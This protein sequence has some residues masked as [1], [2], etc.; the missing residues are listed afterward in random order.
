M[1][2]NP[3][4]QKIFQI[5]FILI[6][7][8]GVILILRQP[9][10]RPQTPRMEKV[11]KD[12]RKAKRRFDQRTAEA[13]AKESDVALVRGLLAENLGD[14]TFSFATVCEAVSGKK[15]IPLDQSPPQQRVIKAIEAALSKILPQLSKTD[16]PIRKLRRINEAS[17]FFEDALL[18][19]LNA[20][21]GLK[22]EIPSTRDGAHQRS[23]YPDLRITDQKTGTVF[24]L[25]PKL[26]EQGS[27]NSTFRSFYFEPKTETSKIHDDAVHLLVGIEHNGKTRAWTFSGWRIVDLSTMEVRLKAEF[28]ATNADLY[29]ETELSLPADKP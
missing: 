11:E 5:I 6:A 22:C 1:K 3:S 24:Y 23:G 7:I 27:D 14:R 13:S 16:S 21:P 4:R 19:N 9:A 26:V 12:L 2:S 20:T 17:R 8:F 25:D 29:R 18:E 10:A 28:Q 15:V